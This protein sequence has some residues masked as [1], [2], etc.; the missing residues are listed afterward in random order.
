MEGRTVLIIAHRLSTIQNANSVAVLDQGRI[1]ECG[2]H[3][4]LL[5]NPNGLFS[6]LMKKQSF[7]Q[8]IEHFASN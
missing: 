8:N 3:E 1:V 6:K 2:K 4:T 7:I 5:A